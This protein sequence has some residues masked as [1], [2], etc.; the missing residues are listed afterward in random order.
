MR[1]TII[2]CTYNRCESLAKALESAAALDLPAPDEW[3]VLVVDNN[4][5]DQTREVVEG[6]CRRYPGQFNYVFEPNQGKSYAL[7]S[8]I[9]QACGDVIAFLDDDVE[10]DSGWLRNL[11][12]P[13]KDKKWVGAGGRVLPE[14]GFVPS[15][16]MDVNSRDGLAPLAIFDLGLEAGELEEAPFGTNMA[17]RKEAFEKYGGFRTDLGPRPGSEIRN[18]DSEFS[19]RLLAAGERL[20][21]E[22]SAVVYHIIPKNR[23][24]RKYFQVW[25]FDKGRA[26]IR[27]LGIPTDTKWRMAGIPIHL[28]R[29]LVVWTLRWA[30]SLH[31]PERFSSKLKV[32][33][34]AGSVLECHR[35][36]RQA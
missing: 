26:G 31:E 23:T 20:W 36:A 28:L 30:T 14:A 13:L 10:V 8:G 3:D 9:H 35:K 15:R 17:F 25:W 33:W 2:L 27:E 7:N 19:S 6:F 5:S 34:L 16:W 18:E 32:W 12:A 4:S 21:Y 22:P 11:T 24:R 1:T 29:R